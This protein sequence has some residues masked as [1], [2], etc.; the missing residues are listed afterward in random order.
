MRLLLT[1][2][3]AGDGDLA[4][5][6]ETF[7]LSVTADGPFDLDDVLDRDQLGQDFQIQSVSL[8]RE[9][10]EYYSHSNE[11]YPV[12]LDSPE[13]DNDDPIPSIVITRVADNDDHCGLVEVPEDG[14]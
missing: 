9:D 1:C 14:Y 11:E 5:D 4:A 8:L 3:A 6:G 13:G 10:V 7:F 2:Y 12:C